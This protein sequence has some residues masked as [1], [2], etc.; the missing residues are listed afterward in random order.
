MKLYLYHG[1]T[2]NKFKDIE[3]CNFIKTTTSELTHYPL[4]GR[5][6]TREGY[7]YLTSDPLVALE[8]ASK[9]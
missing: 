1:T 8:F 5:A 3:N 9:C 4:E 7:V 6:K 2:Y